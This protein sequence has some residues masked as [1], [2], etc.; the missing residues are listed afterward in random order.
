MVEFR[1]V[2]SKLGRAHGSLA[3]PVPG[4]LRLIFFIFQPRP[5]TVSKAKCISLL[6]MPKLYLYFP[7]LFSFA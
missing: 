6:C 4:S 1:G 2:F 5:V 3:L 7:F